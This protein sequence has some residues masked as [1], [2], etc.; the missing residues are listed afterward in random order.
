MEMMDIET[1]GYVSID[2]NNA[3]EDEDESSEPANEYDTQE[4]DAEGEDEDEDEED[5]D[6]DDDE[7]IDMLAYLRATDPE[8]VAMREAEFEDAISS[9]AQFK[10]RSIVATAST[11]G[12]DESSIY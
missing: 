9:H 4:G 1:A 12:S 11:S 8:G 2:A 5:D 7:S 6:D 3:K 10:P